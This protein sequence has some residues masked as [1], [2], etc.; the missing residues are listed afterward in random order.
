MAT[1]AIF[2]VGEMK[3]DRYAYYQDGAQTPHGRGV[4]INGRHN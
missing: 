4:R 2:G 3:L 1:R